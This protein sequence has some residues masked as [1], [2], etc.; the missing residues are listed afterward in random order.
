MSRVHHAEVEQS[1]TGKSASVRWAALILVALVVGFAFV[2]TSMAPGR[3]TTT[4][5]Y[6]SIDM[7]KASGDATY[8]SLIV[9]QEGGDPAHEFDHI[10][11]PLQGVDGI[12]EVKLDWSSGI[13]LEVTYDSSAIAE[14]ELA[15][16]VAS[17]GYAGVPA[18]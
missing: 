9:L 6:V 17:T 5:T 12:A 16:L 3:R 8:R 15:A 1:V 18:Q 2:V 14:D 13:W 11:Q 7:S 4:D 10:V